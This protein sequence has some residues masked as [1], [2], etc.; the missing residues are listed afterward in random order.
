MSIASALA[1]GAFQ[2]L[3]FLIEVATAGNLT[4]YG[5]VVLTFQH[6]FFLIEVA[7]CCLPSIMPPYGD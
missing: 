3:F 6:L 1:D 2:H 4:Q 5:Q 7:T